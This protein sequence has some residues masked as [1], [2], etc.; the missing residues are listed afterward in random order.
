MSGRLARALT[1]F[2]KAHYPFKN[3]RHVRAESVLF[4]GCN[5]VSLY[6]QTVSEAARVLYEAAGVGVAYDCCGAP[7]AADAPDDVARVT[8]GVERRLLARGV[9]ELV[10]LCPTCD[11]HFRAYLHKGR[12]EG[13]DMRT[14]SV[15][16]KLREV[17][18][19]AGLPADGAVFVPC[20]DRQD[21]RWLGD[22][23]SFFEDIPPV[24]TRV[25]CCGLGEGAGY[26]NPHA[27]HAMA[28]RAVERCEAAA[29]GAPYVYCASCA[30]SFARHGCAE[31][32]YVLAEILGTHE[33][34]QVARS[35]ANRAASKFR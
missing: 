31:V 20:P 2:E 25:P 6:P 21:K 28:R 27:M 22:V 35:L 17:G 14:V 13:C 29:P 1:S 33:R 8:G 3:Y 5:A 7:V 32:R 4:V 12:G 24:P 15:Y 26:A 10:L 34:A 30:G 9:R 18:L 23:L 19:G 16:A 11:A